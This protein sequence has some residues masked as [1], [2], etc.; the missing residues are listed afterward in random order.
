MFEFVEYI[1]TPI[2]NWIID[3]ISGMGYSGIV[4]LMAIESACIPLPSEVIMPFSGYLVSTGRFNI[5]LASFAGAFG[6]AVGSTVT[7]WVGYFGGRA[8][9]EKWGRFILIRKEELERADRWF[10]KY[11]SSAAFFSRLLPIIRTFISLPAGISR[12]NFWRFLLYSFVGSIPWCY[13]LAYIGLVMG[14]NWENIREIFRKFD[15]FIVV[16]LALILI[17]W[18]VVR[19]RKRRSKSEIDQ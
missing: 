19:L 16:I 14:E 10:E 15:I 13:L 3:V 1:L 6:C 5:H 12:M 17:W 7:Y 18:L 9:I 4:V 11:G 2:I 8:F